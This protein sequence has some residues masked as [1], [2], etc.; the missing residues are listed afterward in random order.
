MQTPPILSQLQGFGQ[1]FLI[2]N[3]LKRLNRLNLFLIF[4]SCF[5]LV[6]DDFPEE[7]HVTKVETAEI[8]ESKLE[9]VEKYVE[10]E[11][12]TEDETF[13]ETKELGEFKAE[14]AER[15]ERA[16]PKSKDLNIV[17]QSL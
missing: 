3:G 6:V 8:S 13:E 12:K 4:I 15:A 1:Q 9:A 2:R 10:P 16:A 7:V 14:S 17:A 11:L 5:I